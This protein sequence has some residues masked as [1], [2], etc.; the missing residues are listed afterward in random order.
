[1]ARRKDK[2]EELAAKLSNQKGQIY[3]IQT[4]LSK[5]EEILN[6]FKIIKEKL[7]SVSILVNNAGVAYYGLLLDESNEN[8]ADTFLVNVV[9]LCTATKE[10]VKSMRE[11]SI[12]G[13]I[14]NINSVLG[15]EVLNIRHTSYPA[16][17]HAVTA[18]TE[19]LRLE[20]VALGLKIKITVR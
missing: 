5:E 7:G 8:T 1:M 6:A 18:L 14:F 15:H 20:F 19:T 9:G 16:S 3:P 17:K 13:H 2:L 4:D 11:N 12:A 10:A